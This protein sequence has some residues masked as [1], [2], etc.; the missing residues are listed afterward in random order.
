M[1]ASDPHFLVRLT[2]ESTLE[3]LPFWD[4]ALPESAPGRH[5][6]ELF[7]NDHHLPGILIFGLDGFK[8]M[9]SREGF[10]NWVGLRFGV[11]LFYH[12]PLSY[13]MKKINEPGII[14][15]HRTPIP[16]AAEACLHR[17]GDAMYEALVVTFPDQSPRLVDFRDLL[18][19]ETRLLVMAKEAKDQFLSTMSHELKTPLTS[20]LGYAEVMNDYAELTG[21]PKPRTWAGKIRSSGKHL[22]QLIDSVLDLSKIDAGQMTM[23]L[24]TFDVSDVVGDVHETVVPLAEHNE[25]HFRVTCPANIGTM[26]ADPVKVRQNLLNLLGNACKFTTKG[27]VSLEVERDNGWIVFS[28]RDTGIGMTPEQMAKIF[29]PFIQADS[30]TTRRYGGTGLGL[31]IAHRFCELMGGKI[32]VESEPGRGTIFRMRLPT[33]VSS[34]VILNGHQT[35]GVEHPRTQPLSEERT[36]A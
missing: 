27:E 8:G 16:T 22:L 24:H 15:D 35:N 32:T 31:S 5:A 18:V 1:P 14:L 21:Q 34:R 12:R 7:E 28:I 3:E 25:N 33:E 20:M 36:A 11:D 13:L 9:I 2:T 26:H 29:Q 19:A 6:A 17:K 4:V 30:S 23:D 10:Y